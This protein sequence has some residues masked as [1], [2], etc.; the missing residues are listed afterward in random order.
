MRVSAHGAKS[1]LDY[2]ASHMRDNDGWGS[3]YLCIHLPRCIG[4]VYVRL[5]A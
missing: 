2:L 4:L 5:H 1:L 3:P